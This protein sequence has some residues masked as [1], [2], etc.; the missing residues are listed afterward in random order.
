VRAAAT[1]TGNRVYILVE[2]IRTRSAQYAMCGALVERL[3]RPCRDGRPRIID[4]WLA[5]A[6][7]KQI[8]FFL[9]ATFWSSKRDCPSRASRVV[10][11]SRTNRSTKAIL[12]VA[13]D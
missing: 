12:R 1:H 7:K 6:K 2:N 5:L 13:D 9:K 3:F 10:G 11:W 8:F 4:R